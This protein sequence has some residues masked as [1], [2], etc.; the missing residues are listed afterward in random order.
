M[1]SEKGTRLGSCIPGGILNKWFPRVIR[2]LMRRVTG[3]Q[4][5]AI[6]FPQSRL[7]SSDGI[8]CDV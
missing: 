6:Q 4:D 7:L 5:A 3:I 8:K 2:L 1:R